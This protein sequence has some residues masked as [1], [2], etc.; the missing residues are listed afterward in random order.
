[1]FR[2]TGSWRQNEASSQGGREWR[3]T[4]NNQQPQPLHTTAAAPAPP[5]TLQLALPPA[6]PAPAP[7][8][9]ALPPAPPAPAPL[10]LALPPP[11][12]AAAT[13]PSAEGPSAR[14][15]ARLS[16]RDDAGARAGG[17]ADDSTKPG[18][19]A[20]EASA[21][22][23]APAAAP[24]GAADAAARLAW[25][26]KSSCVDHQAK[27]PQP[28]RGQPNAPVE[29]ELAKS[30]CCGLLCAGS[31]FLRSTNR[32]GACSDTRSCDLM[33]A[34]DVFFACLSECAFA[35]GFGH[36]SGARR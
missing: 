15:M 32:F 3:S 11:E 1:M 14:E 31:N 12:P 34:N 23:S 33:C 26:R 28:N 10:Q 18:T 17:A 19:H 24:L 6:P 30:N 27:I 9:L 2:L 16:P 4:S 20:A 25:V 13:G 21:A 22:G 36:C 8:Q 29:A 5:A 35:A 7:L